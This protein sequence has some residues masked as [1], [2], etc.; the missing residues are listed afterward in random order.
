MNLRMPSVLPTLIPAFRMGLCTYLQYLLEVCLQAS[1]S[2]Q[3]G[4]P[5]PL[6]F[7]FQLC[8]RLLQLP[9]TALTLILHGKRSGTLLPKPFL[10]YQHLRRLL[11]VQGW[12]SSNKQVPSCHRLQ[13]LQA[14]KLQRM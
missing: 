2:L 11:S 4:P 7:C 10:Q 6:Y 13:L 1:G 5:Y 9:G 8:F 12:K 3:Q 14:V